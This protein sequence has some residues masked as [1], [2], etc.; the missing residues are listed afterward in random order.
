MSV[1][2]IIA[3]YDCGRRNQRMGAGALELAEACRS[4]LKGLDV[5][6]IEV[7]ADDGFPVEIG[8][9]FRVCREIACHVAQAHSDGHFPVVLA[10]NCL[11]AIGAA[12]GIR[13]DGV[14]WFDQHGDLNRPE[15]SLSGMLDGM[16]FAILLGRAWNALAS[17]V[18]GFAPVDE[19]RA[20]LVDGRDLDPD[21]QEFLKHSALRHVATASAAAAVREVSEAGAKRVYC[22]I[23]LDVHDPATLRVNAFATNGGPDPLTLRCAVAGV[24][25][26][27]PVQAVT[28]CS[29]DPAHDPDA[30]VPPVA[31]T[32]LRCLVEARE[33]KIC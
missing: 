20:I 32:L 22:H 28:L 30:R 23:D 1:A 24:M 12:A 31:A 25:T 17:T 8:T 2:L 33:G 7:D 3:P 16:P 9:G 11:A 4:T 14:V 18:P 6:E 21:E 10:G 5:T 15:T 26:A 27:A 29:Y 13:A 19:A